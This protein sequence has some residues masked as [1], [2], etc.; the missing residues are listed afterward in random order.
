MQV[1]KKALEDWFPLPD[2]PEGSEI[3]VRLLTVG[4][5]KDVAESMAMFET[6]TVITAEG[7]RVQEMRERKLGNDRYLRLCA[8]VPEWRN[9]IDKDGAPLPCTTEN[10]IA[11]AREDE[12]FDPFVAQCHKVLVERQKA[13]RGAERKNSSNGAAGSPA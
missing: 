6:V 8:L 1:G 10:K 13:Q 5:E 7:K 9:V 4:E 3:L 11:L 12:K 2:D